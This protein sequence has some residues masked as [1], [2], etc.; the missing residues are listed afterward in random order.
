MK[1]KLKLGEIY[2]LSSEI[3][4]FTNSQTG[5][6]LSKGLLG[7]QLSLVTK[8]KVSE[9]RDL[10]TSHVKNI[11]TLR[12]E[13]IKKLGTVDETTGQISLSYTI[14]EGE[15]N[16]IVNPKFVEFNRSLEELLKQEKELEVPEFKIEEFDIKTEEN[17]DVFFKLLKSSTN[18]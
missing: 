8:F 18:I 10:L 16:V 15:D 6:K 4:G 12:E 14:K 1:I 3:S 7:Q 11:D 13:L 9:L 5:E 17:Y 2:G